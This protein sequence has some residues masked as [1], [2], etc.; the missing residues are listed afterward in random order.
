MAETTAGPCPEQVSWSDRRETASARDLILAVAA[1]ATLLA[2]L[3]SFDVIERL[4][5][6]TR[7]H[8]DW[9]LDEILASIP[10]LVLVMTWYAVRR[11]VEA[12]R[13]SLALADA[14][15]TLKES[16][17]RILAA[18]AQVRDAQRF[19]ALGRLAGGLAHELN[20]MLQP[21]ITL[22]Q[23]TLKDQTLPASARKNLGRILDASVCSREIISKAL[24]FAGDKALKRERVDFAHCLKEVVALSQTA[25]FLMWSRII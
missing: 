23:L 9:E 2:F 8:E 1:F 24:T 25:R 21:A 15:E 14:N 16:H 5:H 13:L 3:I 11:W 4:F 6:F 17:S 22:T 19:E 12:R 20:N 7:A 18:E 10:A